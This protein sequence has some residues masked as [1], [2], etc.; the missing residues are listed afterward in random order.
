MTDWSAILV[1]AFE[2]THRNDGDTGY[3]GY[4][5]AKAL[6]ATPNLPGAVVTTRN[7]QAVTLVTAASSADAVTTVTTASLP[8][9]DKVGNAIPSTEQ[10]HPRPV[11]NVTTVTSDIESVGKQA[12]EQLRSMAPLESFGAEA[13]RQ[14]LLDAETFF[15]RWSAP[16]KLLGWS[17][18]DLLGVHPCA[19]A[20]RFDAM[21][22]L[23]LIR[24]GE[25]I[26]LQDQCVRIRSQGG[27]LLVYRKHGYAGAVP[28]WE[29]G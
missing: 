5:M 21:G 25:V 26:E 10:L 3:T 18:E 9:G 2:T 11:T 4:R 13:W 24:G 22:L 7:K 29:V 12:L 27:S 8:V 16:A 19:P 28:L 1:R 15:Q 17:D 20:A 6:R 14:L 23:L